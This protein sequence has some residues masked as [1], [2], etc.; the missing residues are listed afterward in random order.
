M[1]VG[2]GGGLWDPEC[3]W[4]GVSGKRW[5]QGRCLGFPL[6][7]EKHKPTLVPGDLPF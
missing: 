2:R 4:E 5:G 1:E 7:S 6:W 3:G